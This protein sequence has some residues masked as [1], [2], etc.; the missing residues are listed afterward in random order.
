M[1]R[2][3]LDDLDKPAGLNFGID[4]ATLLLAFNANAAL[5]DNDCEADADIETGPIS[6]L[7]DAIA[8]SSPSVDAAVAQLKPPGAARALQLLGR[9]DSTASARTCASSDTVPPRNCNYHRKVTEYS[10][11]PDDT[12]RMKS[13]MEYHAHHHG[14]HSLDGGYHSPPPPADDDEPAVDLANTSSCMSPMKADQE[15]VV[16]TDTPGRIRGMLGGECSSIPN[17]DHGNSPASTVTPEALLLA[18]FITTSPNNNGMPTTSSEHNSR[19]HSPRKLSSPLVAAME[20][21]QRTQVHNVLSSPRIIRLIRETDKTRGMLL[22]ALQ[23]GGTTATATTGAAASGTTTSSTSSYPGPPSR[24]AIGVPTGS[25]SSTSSLSSAPFP[26]YSNRSSHKKKSA[27]G[28]EARHQDLKYMTLRAKMNEEELVLKRAVHHWNLGAAPKSKKR[29]RQLLPTT[30]AKHH[31]RVQVVGFNNQE[32]AL[33]AEL[34]RLANEQMMA[35]Q[36][37][38]STFV[39]EASSR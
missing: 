36:S 11:V 6:P 13:V 38:Y 17:N 39:R 12:G 24:R 4:E 33:K 19:R 32:S 7:E 31:Q 9:L 27:S 25:S 29:H 10:S 1:R 21:S 16:L 37:V 35:D 23:H 2:T 15:V 5:L 34:Q 8:T 30:P 28:W 22:G 3:S 20:N 26:A 18:P 14:R